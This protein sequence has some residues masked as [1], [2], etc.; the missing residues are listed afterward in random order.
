MLILTRKSNESVIINR[1]IE[2]KIIDIQK[3]QVKIGFSAPKEIEIYRKEVY[4]GIQRENIEA[5]SAI[6]NKQRVKPEKQFRSD[7]DKN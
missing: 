1:N 3:K 4:E 2:V 5:A 7:E 6:K